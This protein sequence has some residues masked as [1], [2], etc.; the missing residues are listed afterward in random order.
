MPESVTTVNV[1]DLEFK[2]YQDPKT[3]AMTCQMCGRRGQAFGW[4]YAEIKF[5]PDAD[6]T[7]NI[8]S[9]PC[10]MQFKNHPGVNEFITDR[11]RECKRLHGLPPQRKTGF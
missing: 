10:L 4:L 7:I 1:K 8:C 3:P 5:A 2:N 9:E 6:Y 11:V